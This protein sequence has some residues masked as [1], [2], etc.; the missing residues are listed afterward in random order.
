MRHCSS[1]LDPGPLPD[2]WPTL[3]LWSGC[4]PPVRTALGVSCNTFPSPFPS[5]SPLHQTCRSFFQSSSVIFYSP[6][7]DYFCFVSVSTGTSQKCL[8]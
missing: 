4:S 7:R 2:G 8:G 5:F 1:S 3:M 6:G